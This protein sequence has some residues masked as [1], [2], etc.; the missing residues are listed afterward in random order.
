MMATKNVFTVI[1]CVNNIYRIYR[2]SNFN[3]L[4]Q[5]DRLNLLLIKNRWNGWNITFWFAL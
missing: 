5:V 4:I 3:L 2:V 1:C